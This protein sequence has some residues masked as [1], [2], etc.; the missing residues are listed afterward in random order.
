[1]TKKTRTRIN[2]KINN[3]IALLDDVDEYVS[4]MLCMSDADDGE[5]Y[6]IKNINQIRGVLNDLRPKEMQL[7][8]PRC[9]NKGILLH[10]FD[11]DFF[12]RKVECLDCGF[13]W[14]EAFEFSHNE[15]MEGAAFDHLR[16]EL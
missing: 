15:D 4:L 2:L 16:S 9:E 14:I 11:E 5:F 10:R 1:M 8:C 13:A 3:A 6:L 12:T 7:A